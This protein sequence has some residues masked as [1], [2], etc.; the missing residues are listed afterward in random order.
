[1]RKAHFPA[2]S[3][4]LQTRFFFFLLFSISLRI[5]S[6]RS[7]ALGNVLWF[8]IPHFPD[9]KLGLL[10]PGGTATKI[11]PPGHRGLAG[12]HETASSSE[13][14]VPPT[15][16]PRPG[17]QPQGKPGLP[18]RLCQPCRPAFHA[19]SSTLDLVREGMSVHLVRD[20]VR[21]GNM[22]HLPL[23]VRRL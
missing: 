9:P 3:L 19:S 23:N 16:P 18:C 15:L 4:P 12:A 17:S 8:N 13:V 5:Q 14:G 20:P 7:L 6:V 10:F 1:M 21:N 11:K 22:R 2:C